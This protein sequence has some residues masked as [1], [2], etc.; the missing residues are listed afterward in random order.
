MELH[1]QRGGFSNIGRV[2]KWRSGAALKL[3]VCEDR[4]WPDSRDQ[5]PV[6]GGVP[7]EAN[8]HTPR[9]EPLRLRFDPQPP[10][11]VRDWTPHCSHW[12][13]AVAAREPRCSVS[14]GT[15]GEPGPAA[16]SQGSG[17]ASFG[18]WSGT[19]SWNRAAAEAGP[20]VHTHRGSTV[21]PLRMPSEFRRR[22]E[23]LR[24]DWCT[25]YD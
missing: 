17:G 15:Q 12:Y 20:H 5:C 10:F 22:I 3:P 13:A 2:L 19:M 23:R 16:A 25:P 24:P 6:T 21:V 14:S 1:P 18:V 9:R 11:D 4:S 7:Y 8:W